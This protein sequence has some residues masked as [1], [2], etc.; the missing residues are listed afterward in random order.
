MQGR[1][2]SVWLAVK[3]SSGLGSKYPSFACAQFQDS[4]PSATWIPHLGRQGDLTDGVVLWTK[5]YPLTI[6]H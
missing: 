3:G 6:L 5:V 1:A 2:P 4:T